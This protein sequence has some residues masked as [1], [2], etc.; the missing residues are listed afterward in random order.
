ME[1]PNMLLYVVGNYE[2]V[3][4]FEQEAHWKGRR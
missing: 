1:M 4:M 2:K 3:E